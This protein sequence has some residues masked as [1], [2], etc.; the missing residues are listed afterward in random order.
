MA[1]LI[2]TQSSSISITPS[3]LSPLTASIGIDERPH[4]A[5]SMNRDQRPETPASTADISLGLSVDLLS[6]STPQ[7]ASDSSTTSS[8]PPQPFSDSSTTSSNPPQPSSDS[9]TT[10]SNPPQPSSDSST[11]SSNPPQPSSDSST[12]SSNP[13][14]DD[15]ESCS[16]RKLHKERAKMLPEIAGVKSA[17]FTG[18][19][20]AYNETCSPIGK[21]TGKSTAVVWHQGMMGRN[22]EDVVSAYLKALEQSEFNSRPEVVIWADNCSAQNKNWTLISTLAGMMAEM[23]P[24]STVLDTITIKYFE[25][26][27]TFMSADSFHALAEEAFKKARNIFDFPHYVDYINSVGRALPMRQGDFVDFRSFLSQGK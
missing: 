22:D 25:A 2:Q 11:T 1:K 16:E 8:N 21:G 9:S 14:G 27:H 5:V 15:C 4:R 3:T 12:T 17:V 10:S 6:S 18:R 13:P 20:A 26:G 19:I 7:P 23:D 24:E